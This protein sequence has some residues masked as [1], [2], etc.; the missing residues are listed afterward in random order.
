MHTQDT[1]PDDNSDDYGGDYWRVATF[2][3]AEFESI[4][5][6][7]ARYVVGEWN[8]PEEDP[9]VSLTALIMGAFALGLLAGM[10]LA[11]SILASIFAIGR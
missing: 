10:V 2:T 3:P 11:G 6:M 8:T 9:P 4:L 5:R 1:D 7:R